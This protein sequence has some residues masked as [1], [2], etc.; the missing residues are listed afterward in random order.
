MKPK[1]FYIGWHEY[2]NAIKKCIYKIDMEPKTMIDKIVYKASGL[3]RLKQVAKPNFIFA[4]VRGGLVP[5]VIASHWLGIKMYSMEPK[6]L[7]KTI[8][9]YPRNIIKSKKPSVLLIDDISDSGTTFQKC[10]DYLIKLGY[11]VITCAIVM[12][13]GTGFIPDIYELVVSKDRWVMFPY[14]NMDNEKESIEG[15]TNENI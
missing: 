8:H 1:F 3:M 10:S 7:E 6:D 2:L 9:P 12:K 13:V 5:A 4:P 11:N 15:R 14:E